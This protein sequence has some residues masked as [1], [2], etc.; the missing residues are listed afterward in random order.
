MAANAEQTMAAR[1]AAAF[2][3]LTSGCIGNTFMFSHL[4]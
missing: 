2:S 3:A 4:F 1:A